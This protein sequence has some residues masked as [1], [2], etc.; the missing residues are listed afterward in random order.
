MRENLPNAIRP[1]PLLANPIYEHLH[2][3][4]LPGRAGFFPP[5]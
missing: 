2:I 4:I 1:L 3:S 5:T